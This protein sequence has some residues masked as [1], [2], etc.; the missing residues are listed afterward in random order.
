[1]IVC[2]DSVFNSLSD[3]KLL[4]EGIKRNKKYKIQRNEFGQMIIHVNHPGFYRD[5]GYE[6]IYKI[7]EIIYNEIENYTHNI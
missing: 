4:G 5:W 7:F 3:M 2:S 1:M 6:G